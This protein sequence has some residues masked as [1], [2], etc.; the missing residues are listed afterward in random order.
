VRKDGLTNSWDSKALVFALVLMLSSLLCKKK[1]VS[2]DLIEI[3]E[4]AKII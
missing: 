3:F 1:L 4:I 2:G